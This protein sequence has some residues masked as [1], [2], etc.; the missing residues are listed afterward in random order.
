MSYTAPLKDMLF[1]IEHLANIGE[2]AKL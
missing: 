1:D 2:I